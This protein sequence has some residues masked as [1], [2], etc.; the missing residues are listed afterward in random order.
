MMDMGL[1]SPLQELAWWL[2]V[3]LAF[4]VLDRET[5]KLWNRW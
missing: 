4:Y 5:R 1:V 2:A 3:G